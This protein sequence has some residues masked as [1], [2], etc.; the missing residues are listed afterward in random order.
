[1]LGDIRVHCPH[2]AGD[3]AD[4]AG[5]GGDGGVVVGGTNQLLRQHSK[6]FFVEGL[7]GINKNVGSRR[8][9]I[10]YYPLIII[11]GIILFLPP[12]LVRR[13]PRPRLR[14]HD[15]QDCKDGATGR[16]SITTL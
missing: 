1:M 16:A 14:I 12:E 13:G 8:D 11:S 7:R 2:G 10:W 15:L 5:G 3:G 4:G 9:R 6:R